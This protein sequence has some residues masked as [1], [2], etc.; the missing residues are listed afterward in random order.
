[1]KRNM[2]RQG[3]AIVMAVLL[4]MPALP[5]RAEARKGMAAAAGAEA[6]YAVEAVSVM[7]GA[8]NTA[9][10]ASRAEMP[11]CTE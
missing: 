10:L 9:E 7:E 4:A 1:M 11:E 8:R 2:L 5:V 6:G 3:A